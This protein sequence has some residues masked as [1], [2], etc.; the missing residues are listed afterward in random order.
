MSSGRRDQG[1]LATHQFVATRYPYQS[2]QLRRPRVPEP[3]LALWVCY[4]PADRRQKTSRPC[5][6]LLIRKPAIRWLACILG[7]MFRYFMD[8]IFE[9]DRFAL[10]M[11]QRAYGQQEADWNQEV[12]PFIMQLRRL[13]TEKGTPLEQGQRG[14]GASVPIG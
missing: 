6:L 1:A 2:L 11:E 8:S 9:E 5:G 13:L 7:P 14:A 4:V 12:L 10:E 3:S